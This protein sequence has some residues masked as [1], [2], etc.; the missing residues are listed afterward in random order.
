MV[1]AR[2]IAAHPNIKL[3]RDETAVASRTNPPILRS[4]G[5]KLK[6]NNWDG[7][8]GWSCL[9][10]RSC[11]GEKIRGSEAAIESK[12]SGINGMLSNEFGVRESRELWCCHSMNA[13]AKFGSKFS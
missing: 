5:S 3:E 10:R 1:P 6:D 7:T 11:S 12:V 13:D 4:T 2:L 8:E 9:D